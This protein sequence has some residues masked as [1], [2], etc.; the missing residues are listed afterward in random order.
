M[1]DLL[2]IVGL[3]VVSGQAA[4]AIGAV[5]WTRSRPRRMMRWAVRRRA[6]MTRIE[7]VM[8]LAARRGQ[9][10]MVQL[11]IVLVDELTPAL[12]SVRDA[13]GVLGEAYEE[14]E[15]LVRP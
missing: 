3:L 1:I 15:P 14:L 9:R 12:A 10:A 8:W 6:G 11:H 4:V 13:L 5:V 7:S 2:L